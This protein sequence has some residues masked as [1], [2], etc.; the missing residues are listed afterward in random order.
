[1]TFATLLDKL[2]QI[3]A[4]AQAQ[5]FVSV[6]A[7]TLEAEEM[8]LHLERDILEALHEKAH[9]DTARFRHA[10]ALPPF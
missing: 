8:V 10:S 9:K 1:M 6:R 7:L 4:A 2:I 3:E 5:D